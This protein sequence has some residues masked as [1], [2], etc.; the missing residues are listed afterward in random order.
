MNKAFPLLSKRHQSTIR[1]GVRKLASGEYD[2]HLTHKEKK[3]IA[4]KRGRYNKVA[5][6]RKGRNPFESK[7]KRV[8][9]TYRKFMSEVSFKRMDTSSDSD[10]SS[11]ASNEW[12]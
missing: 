10:S 5:S 1:K 12:E 9:D 11:A 6:A 2:D 8:G 3:S 7:N 4:K